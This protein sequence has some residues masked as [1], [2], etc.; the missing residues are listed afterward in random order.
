MQKNNDKMKNIYRLHKSFAG[1]VFV[2]TL[3]M[4]LMFTACNTANI[5]NPESIV[6]L[7][8]QGKSIVW[9]ITIH[10]NNPGG[11]NDYV[12][13]GEAPDAHDGPPAD[14]YD[15]VKPPAPQPPYIRA[16]FNDNLLVPYDTLW[17]DYRYYPGSSKVWNLTVH[18]MPSSGSSPTT[19]TLS[20]NTAEVDESEYT[21]VN[22]CT[23]A[24]VIL[25][26]MLV[27][28]TYIFSCPAYVPQNFKIICS[29]SDN[30]PPVATPDSYSTN[31]DT[32]L[33]IAAPGVLGNDNDPDGDTLTAVKVSNTTHGTVSLNSNG[34]FTYVPT[35]NYYGTDSFTYKAYDGAAYSNV[36]TVTITINSVNDPP[37]VTNIPDQT[38]AEGSSFATINLDGYVSDVDNTDAQMTWTYSGNVQLTVSIVARVA[39]ITV[40]NADWYGVETITFK[41]TDPGGL[42][43]DDPATFTVTNVNDPPVVTN[44]PDQTIAEGSSFA[45]INLDNY[46]SDV[47]NTDA[48]MTWTYS[49]NVEL[50][51]SIVARVATITVPNADWYGVETITFKATDPGGLWDDDPATFTVTNVNDPPVAYPDSYSTNE[52]TTLTIPAPGVLGND[53][54]VDG[55]PLTAVKVSN[56]THGTVTL[57]S[58]GGFTYTPA[59]N[60]VGVDTFT[61]KAYDGTV[62][63]NIATVTITVNPVNQPPVAN[64]DTATVPMDS[65]NNKIDVLAN[66]VDP[67]EDPLTITGVSGAVHGTTTTDGSF[68]YYSPTPGYSGSDSFTYTISDGHGGTDTGAVAITVQ[69]N[70]PPLKPQRPTGPAS[71]KVRIEY[72]Y[73]ATTTDPNN[74]QLSYQWDWGDGTTSGWLGPYD[75]GELTQAKHTWTKKG[76]YGI[77]VKAKDSYGAESNWS[78]SLP[79]TMPVTQN[80]IVHE[81]GALIHLIIRFLRGEFAGMTFIQILRMEGWFR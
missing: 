66:D 55:D 64:D 39:T 12:V 10:C 57:N 21:T 65:T 6:S 49:G 30:Q 40:P 47:D 11:Q 15:V 46:V 27:N 56:T 70:A 37:V 18:W 80:Y 2:V 72:T 26:N 79:I 77:K 36:V 58:N 38:I 22:L 14:I 69:P 25:Q 62:Y 1:K 68:V 41:A 51:V 73:N 43:D 34:G 19:I 23:E 48:Q 35:G 81:F 16:W 78:E 53:V 33:T 74:H 28:S 17:M 13:F 54:D 63:S 67:D 60:Y 5:Q 32:T 4:L 3:T 61:Y 9:D 20:W 76:S 52:D 29:A 7:K 44:I 75:S 50:T 8:N 31:E 45:T 59:E 42:W 24:G 71:G